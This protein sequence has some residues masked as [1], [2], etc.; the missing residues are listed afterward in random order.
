MTR[1]R[2]I[3]VVLA[4]VVS[5]GIAAPLAGTAAAEQICIVYDDDRRGLCVEW[6]SDDLARR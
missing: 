3:R 1:A 2:T 5:V 6:F 4:A